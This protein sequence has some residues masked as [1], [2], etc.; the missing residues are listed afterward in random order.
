[1]DDYTKQLERRVIQLEEKIAQHNV[2]HKDL[3]YSFNV[4][5]V[6]AN[7][8]RSIVR[9]SLTDLNWIDKW[10]KPEDVNNE[11]AIRYR[12]TMLIATGINGLYKRKIEFL[13]YVKENGRFHELEIKAEEQ[14]AVIHETSKASGK[15]DKLIEELEQNYE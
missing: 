11:E 12:H 13:K 14:K 15:I 6:M 2:E 3:Q 4:E 5:R 10:V 7:G 8:F 1:M 9:N